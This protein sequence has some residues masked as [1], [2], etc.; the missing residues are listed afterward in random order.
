MELEMLSITFKTG[1]TIFVIWSFTTDAFYFI[2]FH[3]FSFTYCSDRWLT[4][5]PRD[6]TELE[7]AG[8]MN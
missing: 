5:F 3:V 6:Y 8:G 7:T 2:E 4:L 1:L